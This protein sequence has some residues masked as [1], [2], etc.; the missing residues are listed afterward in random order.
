MPTVQEQLFLYF[1]PWRWRQYDPSKRQELW[2]NE[3]VSYPED[4]NFQQNRCENLKS[5]N[6]LFVSYV[7]I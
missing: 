6:E 2:A 5:R 1:V 4:L 3:T 7:A